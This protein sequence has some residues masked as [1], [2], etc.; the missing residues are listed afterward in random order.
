MKYFRSRAIRINTSHNR[1]SPAKTVE[2]PRIIP[3]FQN[4]AHCK[5]VWRIINTIASLWREDMI[6][7]LSLNIL[8]SSKLAV[9]LELRSPITVHFSG[10]I[11]GQISEHTCFSVP[12]KLDMI[13]LRNH[14]PQSYM[15]RLPMTL[16]V[17]DVTG[18]DFK[19]SLKFSANHKRDSEFN[20]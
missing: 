3:N 6:G 11:R 5:K 19:N 12:N 7:Y 13:T 14:A 2:Y 1:K 17:L 8:C 9:F 4:C 16:S 20:V 15:T 10:Q 18:G